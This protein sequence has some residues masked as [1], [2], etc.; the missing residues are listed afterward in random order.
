MTHIIDNE[1]DNATVFKSM[2]HMIDELNTET[3][4]REFL[5][6]LRWQHEPICPHCGSKNEYHYKLKARGVFKGL[7]KCKDCRSRFTVRVGTMF[8]SSH[9]SLRKW[10]MAIYIFTSHKKGISSLQLHRDLEVTQKTAW[11]MLSRIRNAMKD[12]IAIPF[13]GLVQIDE[14]YVGGKNKSRKKR[15]KNTQG[16]SLKT[17]VPVFG[18]ICNGIVYTKVVKNTKGKTLQPIIRAMVKEG[19][20]VVTDGWLAYNG[21]SKDYKHRV[22]K[23]NK[24]VYKMGPYHTNSIEGFWSQLKR[25]IIGIYHVTSPKHLHRYCDEFSYRYNTRKMS[26]GERFNLSLLNANE[27][28]MYRDL[29]A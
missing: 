15:V 16:R 27:R 6:K 8:E 10:F 9:I 14:T 29:V 24:G 20:T 28:L 1:L 21:L 12:T 23:H 25:G 4:C 18:M 17:K 2:M 26:D 22:I 13:E 7:Y 3:A 19:S 5:E 11:Y